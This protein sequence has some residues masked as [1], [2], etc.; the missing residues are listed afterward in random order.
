M[1][2][3][4]ILQGRSIEKPKV[5]KA[6]SDRSKARIEVEK[7]QYLTGR[8][9]H[10]CADMTAGFEPYVKTNGNSFQTDEAWNI[11]ANPDTPTSMA[12]E[13]SGGGLYSIGHPPYQ[14]GNP[15][16]TFLGGIISEPDRKWIDF[17][18]ME[19]CLICGCPQFSAKLYWEMLEVSHGFF[20]GWTVNGKKFAELDWEDQNSHGK[21]G[22]ATT[23]LEDDKIVWGKLQF[24]SFYWNANSY[25]SHHQN[26]KNLVTHE[27]CHVI[28]NW[29]HGYDTQHDENWKKYMKRCACQPY[30]EVHPAF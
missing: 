19:A 30:P 10:E 4:A 9:Y 6:R 3:D 18:I 27:A 13:L 16:P 29:L 17:W 20:K 2:S 8:N 5:V 7:P 22:L 24:S 21:A 14:P 23:M 28:A 12:R 1:K 15:A 25:T 26:R 11:W